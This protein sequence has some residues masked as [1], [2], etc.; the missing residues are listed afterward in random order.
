MSPAHTCSWRGGERCID[1][2][3]GAEQT[4]VLGHN[5]RDPR[6]L[7]AVKWWISGAVLFGAVLVVVIPR[8]SVYAELSI[9]APP[10]TVWTAIVDTGSYGEWNPIFRSVE[11]VFA[12]GERVVISMRLEDGSFT[13]VEAT[14]EEVI[15][16]RKLR[17]RAGIPGLLTAD[18]Q[19]L[20]EETVTGTRVVQ[21]EEYRG[22][23]VIFYDPSYVQVLYRE[24]LVELKLRIEGADDE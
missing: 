17:Q 18:H 11:G 9:D 13:A 19:W 10:A 5:M 1:G 7:Q 21:K 15:P 22:A 2:R 20:L 24:G 14:V 12:E 6:G 23:G 16:G 3:T 4:G 8:K